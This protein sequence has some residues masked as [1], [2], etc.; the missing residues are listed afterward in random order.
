VLGLLPE[1]SWAVAI[2][3]DDLP[4]GFCVPNPQCSPVP[5]SVLT[6]DLA[7][8]GVIFGRAGESA[9]VAVIDG[10]QVNLGPSSF[11]NT[12]VGLG[13]GGNIPS[14]FTGSIF[15]SFFFPG[16]GVAGVTDFASFTLGDGGGDADSFSIHAF[17]LDDQLVSSFIR[18]VDPADVGRFPVEVAAVGI[19]RLEI[20]RL[21]GQGT[22]FGYS[23][24]DLSFNP[25]QSAGVPL[26]LPE[27]S[28]WMMLLSGLAGCLALKRQ[29]GRRTRRQSTAARHKR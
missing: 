21:V 23:L 28:T 11:A 10:R 8:L 7:H 18:P 6:D 14:N 1:K 9:G 5:D 19:H 16:T 13:S 17:G 27:P 24:D 25:V 12:V 2:N 22:Q 4:A 29:A 3:F 20:Q 26:S 15:F